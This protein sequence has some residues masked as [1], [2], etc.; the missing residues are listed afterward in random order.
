MLS[1]SK[2]IPLEN[3]PRLVGELSQH[4][5]SLTGFISGQSLLEVVLALAIFSLIA[6]AFVSLT[7]GSLANVGYGTDFLVAETIANEGI[8]LKRAIRDNAW[9]VLA[10]GAETATLE[11]RFN[12]TTTISPINL[13]T[14]LAKVEIAWPSP[15]GATQTVTR[16]TYLTNWD[17]RDWIETDWSAGDYESDDGNLDVT[18]AGEVKLRATSVSDGSANSGF[19]TGT[20]S[21]SFATWDVESDEVIPTGSWQSAGGNPPDGYASITIPRDANS[22]TVGA[23]WQQ[24]VAV[25]E[26]GLPLLCSTDWRVTAW[27]VQGNQV[28]DF[29]FFIFLD[30]SAGAPVI[31][32]AVWSSPPVTK[33]SKWSGTGPVDCSSSAVTAG[34]YYF[35]IAVW[36]DADDRPRR[37]TGPITVGFD[38]AGVTWQR[39]SYAPSG[40]LLSSAFDL[41]DLSPLQIIEWDE[42]V[43]ACTPACAIRFQIRAAANETALATAPWSPDFTIASGALID[44]SYNGNRW[45]QYRTTLTGDGLST[46]V[47]QEVRINYK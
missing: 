24:V 38:N 41:G 44:P 8:G 37:I 46:P 33:T 39:A 42:Q 29:R 22:D 1:K 16:Q 9:N 10:D 43:S 5:K 25:P 17:S 28:D 13:E 31:E 7:L 27:S 14:K 30:P 19:D 23:Y 34:T 11:G 15:L 32:Q 21:W 26:D 2:F 12:R 20:D 3:T 6:A 18:V 4:G 45:V 35:K 47:L 36:L 40:E